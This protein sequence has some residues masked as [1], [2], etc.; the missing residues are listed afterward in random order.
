MCLVKMIGLLLP[1]HG[2]VSRMGFSEDEGL[3]LLLR[4][5]VSLF[6]WTPFHGIAK[7]V[8]KRNNF[9]RFSEILGYVQDPK[10][11]AYPPESKPSSSSVARGGMSVKRKILK[12]I[13]HPML[14]DV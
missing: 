10:I 1:L 11:F 13:H 6:P 8:D 14:I 12:S 7:R 4:G 5:E 2:G 9:E 3:T